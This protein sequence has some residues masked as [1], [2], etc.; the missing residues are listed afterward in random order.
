MKTQGYGKTSQR[1][2]DSMNSALKER[3]EKKVKNKRRISRLIDKHYRRY[4]KMFE[5]DKQARRF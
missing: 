3:K 4:L 2:A 5:K 1:F